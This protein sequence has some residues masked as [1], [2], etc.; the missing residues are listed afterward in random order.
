MTILGK[1]EVVEHD[2]E[3]ISKEVAAIGTHLEAKGAKRVAVYLP[4]SIEFLASLFACSFYGLTPIL[5]PFNQ[6]HPKAYQL[7]NE[8]GADALICAAGTLPLDDLSKACPQ[9]RQVT[10]VVQ[11]SS[12][13]M[14][15]TGV[16]G[17]AQDKL[18]VSLWHDVVA[19]TPSTDQLPNNAD[20]KTPTDV[21]IVWQ[22][23]D[24]AVRPEIVNFTQENLVS[25][26][27]A[28]VSAVPLR[29]RLSPA[30]LVLPA[31]SFTHSYTLCMTL[32]ALFMH[33]SLVINSVAA[34]GVD[35]TL[36]RRG[37][38]PTVIIASAETLAT[39]H[40]RETAGVTSLA[41]NFGR[42]TQAQTMSAGRMPTDGLLFKLLAPSS[43]KHTPGKLRLIFVSERLGGGSPPI[44]STML[45]DLRLFTRS[46]IIYA[47][48]TA[49]VA[50]AVAQ[51]NVFD[52]RR[53]DGIAHAHFG[54]PLSSVEIKLI[55]RT[56]SEVATNEPRGELLVAGPAV[57]GGSVKLAARGRIR[58]DC[59]LAYA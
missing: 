30:D 24:A 15:W 14:D 58:P 33:A 17:A 53:D 8:T 59:T 22:S 25:A 44:T 26:T 51:T 18:T 52:Y 2:I 55:N 6:P 37:A 4:N 10:W 39:L 29:Q 11:K 31:D 34:P 32:A 40:Q 35:L 48:T 47:L 21:V 3:T 13:Q 1:E 12:R 9:L 56:D 41:Q 20:G 27:A 43:T 46:R 38:A 28:L 42:Y 36:A 7:V 16:P 19:S 54:I 50:G 57:Q 23:T 49:K 5:L 45:S